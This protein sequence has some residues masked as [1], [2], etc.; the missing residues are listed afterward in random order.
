MDLDIYA[1]ELIQNYEH[2]SNK[3]KLKDANA[4]MYEENISCGDKITI[5]LKI[6]KDKVKDVSFEGT[7]C[8]ISMGTASILTDALIGK[9]VK[10]L[11]KMDKEYLLKLISIDPGPV[12]LHCATLSLRAAKKALFKYENK[13]VDTATKE[14]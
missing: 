11:E 9:S 4:S 8:V 5:Y 1:E 3:G 14:L 2:P 7:G 12:R 6:E 10:E 13:Q